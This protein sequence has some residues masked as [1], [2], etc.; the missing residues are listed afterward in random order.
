MSD[1]V[2]IPWSPLARVTAVVA[3]VCTVGSVVMIALFLIAP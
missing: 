1:A 2:R 3:G